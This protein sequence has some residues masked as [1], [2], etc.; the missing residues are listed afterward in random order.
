VC[1]SI[2]GNLFL[3][4][5]CCVR[6]VRRRIINFFS[7]PSHAVGIAV[8]ANF[9]DCLSLWASKIPLDR[10]CTSHTPPLTRSRSQS[11]QKQNILRGVSLY[12]AR[13]NVAWVLYR[14]CLGTLAA[15]LKCKLHQCALRKFRP[16]APVVD[17]T[18]I[19][20][21]VSREPPI[22]VPLIC[23]AGLHLNIENSRTSTRKE[24]S[25]R[26]ENHVRWEVQLQIW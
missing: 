3:S 20:C 2:R 26:R 14:R 21:D 4:C 12:T 23:L 1:V 17:A 10:E 9:G 24:L 8:E 11:R 6:A 16:H 19:R 22:L 25:Q 5:R 15:R 7:L 13:G 18:L